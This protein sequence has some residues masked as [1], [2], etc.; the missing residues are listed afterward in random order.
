MET[1]LEIKGMTCGHCE[2][3]VEKALAEI[4]NVTEVV[5]VSKDSNEALVRGET[6]PEKLIEAVINEGYEARVL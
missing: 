2:S 3:A 6:V 4:P 1:K 5:Y